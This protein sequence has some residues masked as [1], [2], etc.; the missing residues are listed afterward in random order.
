MDD[1]AQIEERLARALDRLETRVEALRAPGGEEDENEIARLSRALGDEQEAMAQLEAR[2]DRL[3]RRN[4]AQARRHEV[5]LEE[6]ELRA[7]EAEAVAERV[8]AANGRLREAAEALRAQVVAGQVEGVGINRLMR[9]EI[10]SLTLARQADRDALDA[11]MER[12]A[13]LAGAPEDDEGEEPGDDAP[14]A[15]GET[16]TY[17][18]PED[19]GAQTAGPDGAKEEET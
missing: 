3:R 6:A 7:E 13:P 19:G 2:Y 4:L 10:I 18:A 15:K 17:E 16:P 8:L 9:E 12:L 11:L 1:I 5:E 14:G